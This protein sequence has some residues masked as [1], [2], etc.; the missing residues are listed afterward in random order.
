ML[1]QARLE[2][3]LLQLR[4]EFKELQERTFSEKANS[5]AGMPPLPVITPTPVQEAVPPP[6][7]PLPVVEEP[8]ATEHPEV[9]IVPAWPSPFAV[10]TEPIKEEATPVL[11][12]VAL[13]GEA[14]IPLPEIPAVEGK[15][16]KSGGFEIQFGR[17]L[18]RIGVVLALISLIL[19]ST[20]AY[21][22]LHHLMGPW[23]R[24]TILA[25]ISVGLVVAGLRFERRDSKM[26]VYGRTMAGG[27]LACLYYTLYGATYVA[28]LQVIHN[29][30]F[31]GVLLLGWSA[32]VLYLAEKKKSELLSVFAIA[33]AYFSSAIT[34]VGD[35]TMAANLILSVTAV[36]FLVRNAWTGLSYLCL[37]GTYFGLLRQFVSYDSASNTWFDIAD[38]VTFWPSAMYLAG[39]WMIYTAGVFLAKAPN[40][41]AGKRMA[42]LCLNNGAVIGL[43]ITAA[44]LSGFGHIGAVL[45]LTGG[46]FIATS[47]LSKHMRADASEVTGAY[48]MQGLA[49]ATGGVVITYTGVTRGLLVTTESV[50]SCWSWC[51]FAERYHAD[52]WISQR[53]ARSWFSTH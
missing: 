17:W 44:N 1:R 3:A 26:L 18:A 5:V 50:F 9:P 14:E 33:L 47:Y 8:V 22:H 24:L 19:F 49:I 35:F 7:P 51:F 11:E 15:E 38:D 23:S 6:F 13:K 46:A 53:V 34:P 21:Q 25:V 28:P 40:F 10:V 37:I 12:E 30:V 16:D 41:A 48:L 27:G 42:F 2:E 32:Y 20:I 43:L 4:I 39:A 29:Q 45:C 36:L 52:R 31:G